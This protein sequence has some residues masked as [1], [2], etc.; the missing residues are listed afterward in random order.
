MWV[1]QTTVLF[2]CWITEVTR[3]PRI[4]NTYCF[5]QQHWL[6]E[7]TTMLTLYVQCLYCTTLLS[8]SVQICSVF[9]V[10][11]TVCDNVQC[12]AVRWYCHS[13]AVTTVRFEMRRH[14]STRALKAQYQSR[15]SPST[16]HTCAWQRIL[17]V[18]LG[19]RRENIW[20]KTVKQKWL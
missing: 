7:R 3:A 2:A 4:C 20:L 14:F 19:K 1:R 8:M 15:A 11:C 5:P 10:P 16:A 12:A 17:Y 6:R 18:V 13:L 9:C